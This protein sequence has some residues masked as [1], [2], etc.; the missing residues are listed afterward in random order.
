[1]KIRTRIAKAFYDRRHRRVPRLGTDN[2]LSRASDGQD[3]YVAETFP[4]PDDSRV[5]VEIGGN[6]GITL[7][8]TYYLETEEGWRGVSVEPL[9]RAYRELAKNRKCVTVNACIAEYDGETQFHAISGPPEMLSGIPDKYD[10]LHKRRVRRNLKR[11]N[12]TAKEITVPCYRLDTVLRR[13]GIDR[14]DYLSIDT[15]G[16]EL[17][18]LKTIDLDAVSVEM[19]SVENNYFTHEIEE[20]MSDRGY[21]MVGIAGRD[22]FYRKR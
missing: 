14:I 10:E 18:I 17:D 13:H 11:H 12:A 3:I 1:M 7:S 6:D 15:E 5:F 8:N 2:R 4:N 19:M 21:R 22:E 20:Y 9:P 16:G